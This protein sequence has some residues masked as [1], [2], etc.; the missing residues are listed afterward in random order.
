M[1]PR[2]PY[3]RLRLPDLRLPFGARV[4]AGWILAAS[5]GST[6]LPAAAPTPSP[7]MAG[8]DISSLATMEQHGAVYRDGKRVGDALTLLRARGVDCFRL[9]L[10]VAPDGQ[11]VVTN[12]LAYTLALAKRVKALGA[13][14]L[15]NLHYSD[16]WADPS[17][18]FK[19]AAWA[20]L[21]LPDLAAA[22]RNY[23]REVIATF[24]REGVAPDF[25]QLGNE[26]TNG[27][28]WPEGRVEFSQKDDG[29]AWRRLG[30]LQRA[31]FAGLADASPTERRPRT[32]LHIESPNQLERAVWF[33]QQATD[34]GLPFDLIGVSYYPDW[35]GDLVAL[36]TALT[37]LAR[38]FHKP[39]LVVETAYPWKPDEHWEARPNMTWPLTP[40]GQRRFLREV[41]AVVRAVPDGL[42]A[43]VCYWQPEA[44]PV[45]D[46]GI[47]VGGSCA[48]FDERG[49]L[50][51]AA[52]ALG[53]RR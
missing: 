27:M 11:G 36:R 29:A 52:R 19:P 40:S 1:Y 16:T 37:T 17:K 13:R 8:A 2:F 25:V 44:V 30:E 6:L 47:W 23:T 33:C 38:T 49:V 42:G 46:L 50:L 31:A 51:P 28:L 7:W 22:V 20:E 53:A 9:R 43:G 24:V 5:A 12:D 4:L 15:L 34:A 41:A 21:A 18:Q 3:R 10:F 14:L 45:S 32:I 48:L 39:V 35:H 26:I